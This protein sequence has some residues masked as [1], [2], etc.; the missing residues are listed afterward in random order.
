[1]KLHDELPVDDHLSQIHRAGAGLC[2]NGLLS[3]VPVVTHAWHYC[4]PADA[5]GCSQEGTA[6]G[7]TAGGG[8]CTNDATTGPTSLLP[9]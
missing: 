5:D 9:G 3:L 2:S 4:V 8:R 7:R 1:M 6:P